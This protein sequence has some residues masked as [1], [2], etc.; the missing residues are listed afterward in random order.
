MSRPSQRKKLGW[1]R[2]EI[3][4]YLGGA[5][6]GVTM[7]RTQVLTTALSRPTDEETI[8]IA[9]LTVMRYLGAAGVGEE[10]RR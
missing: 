4:I 1:G 6:T 5:I 2:N 7:A 10:G 9:E 8:G 3:G